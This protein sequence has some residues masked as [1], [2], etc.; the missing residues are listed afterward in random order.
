MSESAS[1]PPIPEVIQGLPHYAVPELELLKSHLDLTLAIRL[2][3]QL[4]TDRVDLVVEPEEEEGVAST[5]KVILRNSEYDLTQADMSLLCAVILSESYR[6]GE[7]SSRDIN[8][9]IE[10]NGR[11]RVINI[12]SPVSGLIGH[13]YL[14][15]TTKKLGLSNEGRAKA[16][17]LV[18]MVLR[19]RNAA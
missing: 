11:P 12:T 17:D 7:F 15:G 4:S 8:D 5:A 9:V 3:G 2:E 10:E 13:G 1:H 16:R 14:V 18:E 6:Q 19:S